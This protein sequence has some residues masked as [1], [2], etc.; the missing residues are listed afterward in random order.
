MSWA[1]FVS[2]DLVQWARLPVALTNNNS[3]D[4]DGVFSGS[5]TVVQGVPVIAYTCVSGV[6][7]R[8]CLARP[9][10]AS[11]PLLL[12][13]VKD[14]A[15]PVI[16]E[17]P[18][19]DLTGDFRDDTTAWYSE[20]AQRWLMAVG[21]NLGNNASIV[22][23]ESADFSTWSLS[24]VLW[25]QP[26]QGMFECPDFYSVDGSPS[27]YAAKV[28]HSGDW[29]TL[30]TYD[31]AARIFTPTTQ[32][33]SYD[34]GQ[35]Y[36]SKSFSDVPNTRRVLWGWVAEEDSAGPQ[37]GWQGMQSLPRLIT[38]DAGVGLL[39]IAPLPDLAALR[40]ATLATVSAQ[41]LPAGAFA[42]LPGVAG[43]QVEVDA[44]FSVPQLALVGSLEVGVAVRV[45]SNTTVQTRV[46]LVAVAAT[47]PLNNTDMPGDDV[48]DYGLPAAA[49][50]AE[51]VA[52]CSA[53]CASMLN[54]AAWTYVRPG[55]PAPSPPYNYAPRCSI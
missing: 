14:S 32:T 43:T 47:G 37:R 31:Q 6:G 48:L 13:W 52:N 11:D 27:L 1:H 35:Y 25:S 41:P 51:N 55:Y 9:A 18:P 16:P 40:N 10:N 8:Q 22:L 30:G 17:L 44:Y 34:F 29:V 20:D 12:D 19:G 2:A 5:I 45:N 15:N 39:D 21:A 26:G 42:L 28:S 53:T 36:A 38:Y 49:P 4:A 7:Q 46:G 3:Y 54:C 50:E 33:V 23:Y 24:N